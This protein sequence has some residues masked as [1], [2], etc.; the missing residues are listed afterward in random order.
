MVLRAP[1]C[2][3]MTGKTWSNHCLLI[4]FLLRGSLIYQKFAWLVAKFKW[5]LPMNRALFRSRISL[6]QFVFVLCYLTPS[7]MMFT[8]NCAV[9]RSITSKCNVQQLQLQRHVLAHCPNIHESIG[10]C[11]TKAYNVKWARNHWLFFDLF[12]LVFCV[13]CSSPFTVLL[14]LFSTF[15]D[16]FRCVRF[17][18][19]FFR[20]THPI[21]ICTIFF[22]HSSSDNP[23]SFIIESKP[24]SH[25]FYAVVQRHEKLLLHFFVRLFVLTCIVS[26]HK[27]M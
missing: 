17:F 19:P 5:K 24:I 10:N 15:F 4:V 6:V 3:E 21:F 23:Y 7:M 2:R 12:V 11:T 1:L 20:G 22:S 14:L 27:W 26:M 8:L 9:L 16:F 25:L 13:S 18:W